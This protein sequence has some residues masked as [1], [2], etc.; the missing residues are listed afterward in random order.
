MKC[1]ILAGGYAK[2]M[3]PLT[4]NQSKALL[5]IN[6]RP[7]IDFIMEKV[8][9]LEDVDEIIISTNARFADDFETYVSSVREN[10]NKPIII[11]AEPTMAEG[12]K[13]GAIGGVAF[14]LDAMNIDD[15]VFIIS[16]DNLS[17][18]DLQ[19]FVNHYKTYDPK[20]ALTA[21]YHEPD[22]EIVKKMSCVMMDSDN[23][24]IAFEEKPQNPK[25]NH[26]SVGFYIY[27]KS[28]LGMFKQYLAKGNNKDSPG[29]FLQWLHQ[30]ALVKGFPFSEYWYDIGSFEVY[31]KV[32][33]K[34]KGN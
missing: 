33:E 29:Y 14:V 4:E 27:P 20:C 12:E 21:I 34:M 28:F 8:S 16:G 22:I 19:S 7:M 13:L 9:L 3:L 32:Q 15:D 11:V 25:S 17:G 5:P 1:I 18:L 26:M 23:K 2:R 30:N 24:I 6:G 10:Y 31:E